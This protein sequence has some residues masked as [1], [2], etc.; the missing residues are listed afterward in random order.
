[1]FNHQTDY[2]DLKQESYK[3]FIRNRLH[4]LDSEYDYE[5][6]DSNDIFKTSSHIIVDLENYKTIYE[7]KGIHLDKNLENMMEKPIA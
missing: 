3:N 7:T 5:Q 2:E 6:E 1:M 4:Y